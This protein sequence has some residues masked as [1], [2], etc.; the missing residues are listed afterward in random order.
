[1]WQGWPSAC[2]AGPAPYPCVPSPPKSTVHMH[3]MYKLVDLSRSLTSNTSAHSASCDRCT[4]CAWDHS[5]G[6]DTVQQTEATVNLSGRGTTNS[7]SAGAAIEESGPS[8]LVDQLLTSYWLWK[9]DGLTQSAVD[10]AVGL[11][12]LPSIRNSQNK[13]CGL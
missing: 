6:S 11:V 10:Y 12:N 7:L 13:Q 2:A 8:S 9:R 5:N 1:M 4:D 3:N